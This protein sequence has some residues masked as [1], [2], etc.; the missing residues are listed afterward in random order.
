MKLRDELDSYWPAYLAHHSHRGNRALHDAGDAVVMLVAG[1]GVLTLNPF[2]IGTGLAMGYTLAFAGHYLVE[3][4][5]P[6]TLRNPI[7][8]GIS[9]WKM[10][11]LAVS[12]RLDAEFEKHGI[13]QRGSSRF[14][15]EALRRKLLPGT[16]HE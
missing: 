2:L 15:V 9:N 5:S 8:A 11:A 1:A 4:N 14:G 13:E 6:A 12:G 3:G 16:A 10:F 7:L